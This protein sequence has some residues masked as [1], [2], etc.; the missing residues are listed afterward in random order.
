MLSFLQKR[1]STEAG[2]RQILKVAFPLILSTGSVSIMLFVDRML[3][4]WA[5]TD[6]IAAALPAGI[7]NWALLCP[8]FGTAAYAATFVAQY[9]GAKKNERVGAAIW[10]GLYISL[11]G[12]LLM[13]LLALFSDQIF[14]VVGHAPRIQKMESD[15][16]SILNFASIFFLVNAV[17]S[18]FYAGRGRAWT[19][20]WLNVCLTF[21]NTLFDYA[22]IFG[23]FGFPIMGI[24]GAGYASFL[25]AGI[26]TA[27][28]AILV[29]SKNHERNY[30]T[31]S[32]WKFDAG[33]FR[34]MLKFGFPS[35]MHFFLDVIGMTVFML[36]VG[37]LGVL[38]GAANNITHQIHLLGLLPLI[39]LGI[40]NGILVGQYQGSERSDLA[41]KSTY[42][43]LQL[44]F[45]Y[46]AIV[47]AAYLLIPS[48]FISPFFFG[49]A[50]PASPELIELI[51]TLLVFVAVF[52]LFESLVIVSSGTLKGAGDT[53]FVMRT[54]AIT[55][56]ALVIAPTVVVIEILHLPVFYA[57]GILAFNLMIVGLV[58]F[59]RFRAGRWK[60]Q[61][62]ID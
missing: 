18:C 54:L 7:L 1:W 5:S 11:I 10:H 42:S 6:Y 46:N 20:V 55:S 61:K 32:G 13:P 51:K 38:E 40:A 17:F 3:L 24:K 34:R 53:S 49:R 52:T 59:G 48:L 25:S 37:R 21:F 23:K 57:W 4:S 19:I 56:F 9:I 47:S 45:I 16:F 60:S 27:L 58:F 22:F 30:H 62:V 35:G 12:G 14:A 28:Y 2:Y 15:Y 41:E 8:F 31:R 39:G 44:A 36:I 29:L 26:V 50:E 43:S 33:L